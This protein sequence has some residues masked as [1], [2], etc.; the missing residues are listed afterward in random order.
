MRMSSLLRTGTTLLVNKDCT[1]FFADV[2]ITS[3]PWHMTSYRCDCIGTAPGIQLRRS[4][5]HDPGES[6]TTS[7][8]THV[9][10]FML[11]LLR[12]LRP[13]G[14]LRRLSGTL[15]PSNCASILALASDVRLGDDPAARVADALGRGDP[16]PAPLRGRSH[17]PRLMP[18]AGRGLIFRGGVK[19]W[20]TWG[21]DSRWFTSRH[22]ARACFEV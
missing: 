15:H 22:P 4:A 13:S 19:A 1:A 21:S 14:P 5:H 18:T 11:R 9:S 7:D 20:S 8:F 2:P 3:I 6:C 10:G 17:G 16:V 12:K